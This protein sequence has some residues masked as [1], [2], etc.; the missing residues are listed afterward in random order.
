MRERGVWIGLVAGAVGLFF[1]LLVLSRGGAYFVV[2]HDLQWFVP[3]AMVG[4]A[5]ALAASRLGAGQANAVV[6]LL[7]VVLGSIGWN[8]LV[9]AYKFGRGVF[10]LLLP[11]VH[12]TGIDW[13]VGI[14]AAGQSFSNAGSGY[15]PFT[16]W[17]GKAFTA[18]SFSTGYV[19]QVCLL[20]GFAVGSAVLCALLVRA[21]LSAA[22]ELSLGGAMSSS[23]GERLRRP[24]DA[25]QRAS[26]LRETSWVGEEHVLAGMGQ[27]L[28]LVAGAHVARGELLAQ[29]AVARVP[30]LER[31]SVDSHA[32]RRDETWVE[33]AQSCIGL[34]GVHPGDVHVPEHQQ[35]L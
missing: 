1:A 10:E 13:R 33:R 31:P 18:V 24:F 7:V 35:R 27:R 23:E 29:L 30:R 25:W 2:V 34:G 14:F 20:V 17:V 12:P 32:R 22:R 28:C 19:I 21:W 16:L 4:I 9:Y 26:L 6:W 3:L 15:P 11:L 8:F 5:T